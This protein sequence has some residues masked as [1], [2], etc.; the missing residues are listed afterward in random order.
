MTPL[1]A[2][3]RKQPPLPEERLLRHLSE[4]LVDVQ[5]RFVSFEDERFG[6]CPVFEFSDDDSEDGVF[7]SCDVL[8]SFVYPSAFYCEVFVVIPILF[9]LNAFVVSEELA[10]CDVVIFHDKVFLSLL[11]LKN[12]SACHEFNQNVLKAIFILP[13]RGQCGA[14]LQTLEEQNQ[15]SRPTRRRRAIDAACRWCRWRFFW[16]CGVCKP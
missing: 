11:G 9:P 6:G 8:F 16:Q 15:K 4:S 3:R 12:H 7:A 1:K 5:D 13:Q 10:D 14:S 2:R